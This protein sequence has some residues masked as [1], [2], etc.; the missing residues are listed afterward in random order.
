MNARRTSSYQ[1]KTFKNMTPKLDLV[2]Y[3]KPNG[4]KIFWLEKMIF[5]DLI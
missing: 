3:K 5:A 4:L 2:G 1:P